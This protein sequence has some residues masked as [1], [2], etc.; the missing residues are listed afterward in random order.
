M[1][2]RDLGSLAM[3]YDLLEQGRRLAVRRGERYYEARSLHE[4]PELHRCA[5]RAELARSHWRQA[6]ELFVQLG[7]PQAEGI[8]PL[9]EPLSVK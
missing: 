2:Y 1:A 5:G 7:T 8:L 4:L 9:I 6:H 3:A